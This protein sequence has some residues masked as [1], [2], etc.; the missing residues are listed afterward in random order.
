MSAPLLGKRRQSHRWASDL[1]MWVAT[2]RWQAFKDGAIDA[3][4]A[5]VLGKLR[6]ELFV[7]HRA[8][9]S[10]RALLRRWYWTLI[11]LH[12]TEICDRCGRPVVPRGMTWWCAP[13]ELWMAVNGQHAGIAC[14]FCFADECWAAGR[15]IHL[16]AVEGV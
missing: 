15:P 9:R 7:A 14:P 12:Q 2:T 1:E 4:W 11:R 3:R 10:R 6:Y 5:R 8:M 13:D 16:E